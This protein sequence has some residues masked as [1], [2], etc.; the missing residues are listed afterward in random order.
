MREVLARPWDVFCDFPLNFVFLFLPIHL[1]MEQVPCLR[2]SRTCL[3]IRGIVRLCNGS[4]KL[5]LTSRMDT[6]I[7][8]SNFD[9]LVSYAPCD[10]S[11]SCKIY[12]AMLKIN[13]VCAL[14][15]KSLKRLYLIRLFI[16]FVLSR[17]RKEKRKS[18]TLKG[19]EIIRRIH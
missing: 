11:Y 12:H 7:C 13:I 17:H 16:V 4:Q 3:E 19:I 6:R 8:V 14:H 1:S 5:V 18:I 9:W 10:W 15:F 2:C